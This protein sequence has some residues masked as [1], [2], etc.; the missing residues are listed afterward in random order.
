MMVRRYEEAYGWSQDSEPMTW[1]LA[2]GGI[3]GGKPH[4]IMMPECRPMISPSQPIPGFQ[5]LP[6]TY[7]VLIYAFMNLGNEDSSGPDL[8][9]A[10]SLLES[11]KVHDSTPNQ[12]CYLILQRLAAWVDPLSSFNCVLTGIPFPGPSGSR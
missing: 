5:L 12:T 8:E 10:S 7:V 4:Q 11:M 6:E 9:T 3:S 2:C 1:F